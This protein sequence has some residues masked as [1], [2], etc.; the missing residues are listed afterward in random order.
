MN[1]SSNAQDALRAVANE[2]PENRLLRSKKVLIDLEKN[3][4]EVTD[5]VVC[6]LRKVLR[7]VKGC[8]TASSEQIAEAGRLLLRLK[9]LDPRRLRRLKRSAGETEEAVEANEPSP[10]NLSGHRPPAD[11]YVPRVLTEQFW[12][13]FDARCK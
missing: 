2:Q 1:I 4:D 12:A 6:A 3:Q 7:S 13:E 9:P 11:N 8:A 5:R 10:N